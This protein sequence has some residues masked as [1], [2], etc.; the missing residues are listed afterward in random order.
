M[1]TFC[2]CLAFVV[3][4]PAIR[5]SAVWLRVHFVL[6]LVGVGCVD[7]SCAFI[8]II[9]ICWQLLL[10]SASLVEFFIILSFFVNGARKC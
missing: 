9:L 7:A 1:N 5:T 3:E 8:L 10:L 2:F 6:L 4:K